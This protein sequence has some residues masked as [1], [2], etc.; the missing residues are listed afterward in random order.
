MKHIVFLIMLTL[1]ALS[2]FAQTDSTVIDN[3]EKTVMQTDLLQDDDSK[4]GADAP[5]TEHDGEA[6]DS[7]FYQ[8]LKT[9]FI[10]GT[11][12]FMSLVAIVLI[13]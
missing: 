3:T 5:I 8:I 9:K 7:G 13:I 1:C 12:A 6:S 10:E 11:P 4:T 2:G